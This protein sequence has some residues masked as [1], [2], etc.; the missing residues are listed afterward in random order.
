MGSRYL[1]LPVDVHPAVFT[2]EPQAYASNVCDCGVGLCGRG[3][4]P[5]QSHQI[6][7]PT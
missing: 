4:A 5:A 7:F 2:R 3:S 1:M 6:L